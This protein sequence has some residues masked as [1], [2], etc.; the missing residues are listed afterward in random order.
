MSK[1]NEAQL[2]PIKRLWMMASD[3]SNQPI[4]INLEPDVFGKS[5]VIPMYI[6]Q[7]DIVEVAMGNDMLCVSVLQ[8]WLM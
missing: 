7:K 6:T 3:I 5:S 8:L 4:Q 2:D 1:Q